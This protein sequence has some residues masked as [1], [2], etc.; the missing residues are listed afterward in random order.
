MNDELDVLIQLASRDGFLS[1]A[2]QNE[3]AEKSGLSLR[4]IEA[5]ILVKGM[6][7]ARYRRNFHAINVNDQYT[8]FNARVSVIGCGGL[9]GYI[10]EELAR[11]GV[12]SITAWDYDVFEEHNL[13]RQVLSNISVLGRNKVDI[14]ATRVKEI[15]PVVNFLGLNMRFEDPKGLELL[16][17]QQVVIDALDSVSSRLILSDTCRRLN[18]PL[19]HGAIGG[20]YGQVCTQL[21]GD[22]TLEQL[23][24]PHQQSQGIESSQGNMACTPAVVASLQVAEVLKLLLNRGELLHRRVMFINLLDMEMTTIN[25]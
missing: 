3:L 21:P 25:L 16:T 9:G 19:V 4:E 18:L 5:A 11:M 22:D 6:L 8:L 23:Y 12:G 13:N 2:A 14:A 10:I 24:G 1:W 7:P 15:N 17:N 20:W